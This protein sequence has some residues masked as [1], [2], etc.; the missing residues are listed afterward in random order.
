MPLSRRALIGLLSLGAA[1]VTAGA[2]RSPPRLYGP[3]R[4][5]WPPAL[6]GAPT[7]SINADGMRT[8]L[9]AARAIVLEPIDAAH[10]AAFLRWRAEHLPGHYALYERFR[11]TVNGIA[12]REEGLPFDQCAVASQRRILRPAL[13]ARSEQSARRRPPRGDERDWALYQRH[14]VREVLTLFARTDAWILLGYEAWPGTARGF[15]RYLHA[16]PRRA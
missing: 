1:A 6:D 14:I 10:Y 3:P 4:P 13:E 2:F 16:P 8:L 12:R 5:V 11:A 9:A 15:T 7:G